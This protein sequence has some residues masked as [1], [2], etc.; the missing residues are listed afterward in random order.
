MYLC[1]ATFFA[2]FDMELFET[3]EATMD[4]VDHGI[5]CLKSTVKVMA[6]IH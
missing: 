6:T 2:R 5:T 4:W 1:L 3:D